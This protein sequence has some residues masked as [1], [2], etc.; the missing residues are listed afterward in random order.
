MDKRVIVVD[1]N[2]AVQ[3]LLEYSLSKDGF[4]VNCVPDSISAMDLAL[5]VKPDLIIASYNP[6]GMN[7]Y[8]FC[9]R[10]KGYNILKDIPIIVLVGYSDSYD[11][12]TL[13]AAG[14]SCYLKKPIE[15]SEL[16]EKVRSLFKIEKKDIVSETTL[17]DISEDAGAA[18]SEG[19]EVITTESEEEKDETVNIE[20]LLGWS[21]PDKPAVSE[22]EKE[23]VALTDVEEDIETTE[24]PHIE[25]EKE[26]LASADEER[27]TISEEGFNIGSDEE[28]EDRIIGEESVQ[29][30]E[31]EDAEEPA[32]TEELEVEMEKEPSLADKEVSDVAS[33]D[34]K[35]YTGEVTEDKIEEEVKRVVSEIVEKI[36][37]DVVPD[38]AEI[39]IKKE[40]ERLTSEK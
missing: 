1:S 39:A 29:E 20:E 34:V 4:E 18:D 19:L 10:V 11:E 37:W 24:T 35:I 15:S 32:K 22:A 3:K 8:D 21:I 16:V 13:L 12:A 5:N 9:K 30:E 7:I 38:L 33:D 36:A 25:E 23:S 27:E 14:V 2:I 40:I 31:S 6:E 28:K 26:D 17:L